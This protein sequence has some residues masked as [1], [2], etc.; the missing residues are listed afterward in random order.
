[1]PFTLRARQA[2]VV[3][4]D[5][6]LMGDAEKVK[7]TVQTYHATQQVQVLRNA[8][9]PR[10]R[11][12]PKAPRP[13]TRTPITTAVTSLARMEGGCEPLEPTGSG[14]AEGSIP[15]RQLRDCEVPPPSSG[16]VAR[17]QH[18]GLGRSI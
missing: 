17:L 14:S 7:D 12:R 3:L 16:I 15:Q 5:A 18:L 13:A 1:M 2:M 4:H 8:S 9:P 10:S 6:I 11:S